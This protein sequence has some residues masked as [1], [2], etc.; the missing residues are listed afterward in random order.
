MHVAN[1]ASVIV[2]GTKRTGSIIDIDTSLETDLKDFFQN[3]TSII[4]EGHSEEKE[5]FFSLP[6]K[7]FLQTLNP[8]Y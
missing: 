6:K 4:E 8:E 7:D 3:S 2:E 5:V 1:Q